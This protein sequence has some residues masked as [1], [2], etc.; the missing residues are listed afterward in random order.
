MAVRGQVRAALAGAD[1]QLVVVN[2]ELSKEAT[3]YLEQLAVRAVDRQVVAMM[4]ADKASPLWDRNAA[5]LARCICKL[6]RLPI[7]YA[8]LL[9]PGGYDVQSGASP[10]GLSNRQLAEL[11]HAGEILFHASRDVWRGLDDFKV[12]SNF[13][14]WRET[15]ARHAKSRYFRTVKLSRKREAVFS[16]LAPAHTWDDGDERPEFDHPEGRPGPEDLAEIH[17]LLDGVK[18]HGAEYV[19]RHPQVGPILDK[20]FDGDLKPATIAKEEGITS[21]DVS[22]DTSDYRKDVK[23]WYQTSYVAEGA[24]R[25]EAPTAP[26][27]S[28]TP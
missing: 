13:D 17:D 11:H 3:E 20:R 5:W 14:T 15:L 25:K 21:Q 9:L 10:A 26:P 23:K 7:S 18:K 1:K 6:M 12:D 4:L 19:E 16:S 28:P 8:P 24:V 22:N 2:G 27:T